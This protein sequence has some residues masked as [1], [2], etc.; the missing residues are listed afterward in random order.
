MNILQSQ[1]L[2]YKSQYGF[3]NE[4]STEYAALEIIDRLMTQM[5]KKETPINIYL[6]LSKA[7]DA[8]DHNIRIQKHEY[9]GIT[10][11]NLDLFQKY[12]TDRKQYVEF[13]STKSDKLDINTGV[14]Q[15][16]IIGP[17]LFIIY[18]NDMSTVC[19]LFAFIIY[20][21]DTTL[22]SI[23]SAFKSRTDEDN[24]G[25][26][27]N[28]EL[29]KI[30]TWLIVNKLSLNVDKTKYTVFHTEQKKINPPIKKIKNNNIME[31]VKDLNFLGL[32]IN[33]N[34]SW[35]SHA[36]KIANSISKTTGIM[37]R[38]K[39]LLPKKNKNNPVQLHDSFTL[40]LLH[41]GMG[42]RM[43]KIK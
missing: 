3:R 30:Y 20:A 33:E 21:D 34:L 29:S 26:E 12:L 19:E 28:K 11:N 1:K 32:I 31:R 23:L 7:F 36:D 27:I 6:D 4:H 2:F 16:S 43:Q 41:I 18:I 10:R 35:K 40:K 38:L 25:T 39:H 42:I 8:L 15:G 13:D 37:N 14:T 24:I 17:L 5:D 22:S 9:Y